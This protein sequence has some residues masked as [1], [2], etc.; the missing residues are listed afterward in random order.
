MAQELT[1]GKVQWI[2]SAL[3]ELCPKVGDGLIR[4][5]CEVA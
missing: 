2:E 3:S 4:R 1:L 5:H